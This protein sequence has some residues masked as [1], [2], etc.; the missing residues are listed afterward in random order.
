MAGIRRALIHCQRAAGLLRNANRTCDLS[1]ARHLAPLIDSIYR[2]PVAGLPLR[3]LSTDTQAAGL[4]PTSSVLDENRR[5]L[6]N[7]LLYRSKQRGFLELDLILGR[8]VEENIQ[9]LDETNLT[10]LVEILDLENPY[11][12]KW[13][14]AQEPAPE[15]VMKNPVFCALH[16][17]IM[18]NLN[19][20][21][22][23]ITRAKPGQPWVSGWNDKRSPGGPVAGNQ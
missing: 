3:F 2:N 1:Q 10:A 9:S 13:L 23:P 5:R 14:T 11:L 18:K 8:W 20:Y 17:K 21:S 6:L 15:V 7:R 4:N 19:D 22:S 16:E 12:W